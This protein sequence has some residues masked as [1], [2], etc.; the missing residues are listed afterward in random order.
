MWNAYV[1]HLTPTEFDRLERAVIDGRRVAVVRGGR[2]LVVFPKR[3]YMRDGR[4]ILDAVHPVTGES[5]SMR[6]D[7]LDRVEVISR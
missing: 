3:L 6:L 1:A 2:E 4:E 5:L 7:D